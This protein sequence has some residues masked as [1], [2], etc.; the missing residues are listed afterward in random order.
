MEDNHVRRPVR[1]A[2][3]LVIA[4]SL[5]HNLVSSVEA[6]TEELLHISMYNAN[7]ETE[8]NKV[9]E[10]FSTDLETLPEDTDGA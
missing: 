5:V 8:L 3:F 4:A 6:A 9:W 2:D 1:L 7:R 10:N